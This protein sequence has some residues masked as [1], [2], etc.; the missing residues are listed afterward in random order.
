MGHFCPFCKTGPGAPEA[1]LFVESELHHG[2]QRAEEQQR[3][4]AD[5]I[6]DAV[7]SHKDG[8]SDSHCLPGAQRGE[9]G[10]WYSPTHVLKLHNIPKLPCIFQAGWKKMH[11]ISAF[12][13]QVRNRGNSNPDSGVNVKPAKPQEQLVFLK[14]LKVWPRKTGLGFPG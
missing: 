9:G 4:W 5:N 11:D 7:P 12:D 1:A 10:L 13:F 14:L 8:L 6:R 3:I 2:G